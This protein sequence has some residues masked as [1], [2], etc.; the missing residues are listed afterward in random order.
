M[1]SKA[2]ITKCK[3]LPLVIDEP[4]DFPGLNKE[5]DEVESDVLGYELNNSQVH[6]KHAPQKRQKKQKYNKGRGESPAE[7]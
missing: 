2:P 4:S 1:N 7:R 6:R 5:A 3:C